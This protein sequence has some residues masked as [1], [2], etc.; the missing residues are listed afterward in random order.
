MVKYLRIYELVGNKGVLIEKLLLHV[1]IILSPILI[2]SIIYERHGY[3]DKIYLFG[4]FQ[5]VAGF[6]CMAF[7]YPAYGLFWDL[8]YIPLTIAFLY[9]G[10]RLVVGR[11]LAKDEVGVRFSLAAPGTNGLKSDRFLIFRVVHK[12]VSTGD[13]GQRTNS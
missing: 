10:Y 1:L 9:C 2:Y 6:F 11:V 3:K 5:A 8:R 7:P 13:K 4:M 12:H